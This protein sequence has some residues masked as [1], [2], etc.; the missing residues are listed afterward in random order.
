MPIVFPHPNEATPEG[1]VAVGGNLEATTLI[2]AYSQGIFPWPIG[3]N[4]PLTWFSPDPRGILFLEKLHLPHSLDKFMKKTNYKVFFN[5]DFE[6][7]IH[8]CSISPHRKDGQKTWILPELQTAYTDLFKQGH[9]FCVEVEYDGE[10]AGGLYGVNLGWSIAGESMFYL[11]DNASKIALYELG[12]KLKEKGIIWLDTQM[13]TEVTELLG[14]H[15]ISRNDFLALLDKAKE[16][17]GEVLNF[18]SPNHFIFS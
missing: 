8:Q 9:A 10:L 18:P 14:A 12:L 3:E 6:S 5:R 7:V 15:N 17:K 1:L 16:K 4:Y 13:V 11:K 2:E